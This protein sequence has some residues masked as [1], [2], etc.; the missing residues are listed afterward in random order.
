MPRPYVPLELESLWSIVKK[1][2][3]KNKNIFQF[4]KYYKLTKN[5]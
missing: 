5:K 4:I 2:I 1:G 3:T